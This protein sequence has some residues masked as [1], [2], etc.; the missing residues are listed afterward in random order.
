MRIRQLFPMPDGSWEPISYVCPHIAQGL[1]V[2]KVYR[3]TVD[4]HVA[5]CDDFA[6]AVCKAKAKNK[7][8]EVW[9]T[10]MTSVRLAI[11]GATVVNT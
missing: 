11:A 4:D 9:A 7:P 3:I 1:Q 8:I 2:K 10:N 6:C 5:E